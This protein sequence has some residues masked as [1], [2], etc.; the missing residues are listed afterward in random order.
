VTDNKLQIKTFR[1]ANKT[2][3]GTL[4]VLYP[5]IPQ[6][7]TSDS[8]KLDIPDVYV[9]LVQ[10]V[11]TLYVLRKLNRPVDPMLENRVTSTLNAYIGQLGL[12]LS[13]KRAE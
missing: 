9:P 7:A 11:S 2:T 6:K 8:A 3:P 10:D 13:P 4:T 5:R 12:E 1:G